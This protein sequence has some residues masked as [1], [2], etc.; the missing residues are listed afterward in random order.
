MPRSNEFER[1]ARRGRDLGGPQ[2]DRLAAVLLSGIAHLACTGSQTLQPLWRGE[3]LH[4]AGSIL[5]LTT[6]LG[7][8]L[9]GAAIDPEQ[10]RLAS[11]LVDTQRQLALHPER[12]PVECSTLLRE[13]LTAFD[14]LFS[15]ATGD[16]QLRTDIHRLTL[17]GFQR[18]ARGVRADRS[19]STVAVGG[20]VDRV[21]GDAVE[22]VAQIRLGV[23]AAELGGPDQV[24]D[25]RGALAT[26]IGSGERPIAPPRP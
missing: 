25:P 2:A 13:A 8:S 4:R 23:Q 5:E 17:P 24:V 6:R 22:H 26:G 10:F 15:P 7:R 11:A 16:V 18:R 20:A 12:V 9:A 14:A 3:A 1:L 21:V 19:R